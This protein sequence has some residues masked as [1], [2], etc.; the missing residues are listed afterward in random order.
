MTAGAAPAPARRAPGPRLTSV[1]LALLGGAAGLLASTQTWFAVVLHDSPDT[2]LAVSGAAALPVLAPLS[3][4]ALAL[5]AALSIA[6]RALAYAVGVLTAA[7]GILVT[8]LAGTIAITAPLS[9]V[10]STVTQATGIAGDDAVAA[11]IEGVTGTAWSYVALVGGLVVLASGAL[12]LATA[13]RW[14]LAGRR[15]RTDET[16]SRRPARGGTGARPDDQVDAFD[17]WDGL[18][19]GDDPTR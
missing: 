17:A 13:H 9:A 12:I 8:V 3:L 2:P 11:L 16:A 19:R 4:A 5:G 1:L 10:A 15:Y 14:R 6:A 18:S 7:V